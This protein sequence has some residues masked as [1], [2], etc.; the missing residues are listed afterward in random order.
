MNRIDSD[1]DRMPHYLR[2]LAASGWLPSPGEMLEVVVMHADCCPH[3]IGDP[4]ACEPT[5]SLEPL[6]R[7]RGV[8]A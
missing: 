3:Q 5:L 7:A 6:Q 1:P 2:A 8:K 4:C